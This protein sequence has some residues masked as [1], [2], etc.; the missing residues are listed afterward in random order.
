MSK[1]KKSEL[2]TFEEI[3]DLLILIA[4][5]LGSS[6]SEVARVLKCGKSTLRKR[7]SFTEKRKN[8]N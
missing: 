2:K 4:A 6:N 5:K 3:R 8:D 7:V 1:K